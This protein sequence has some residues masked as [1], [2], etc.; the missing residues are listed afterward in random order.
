MMTVLSSAATSIKKIIASMTSPT[1]SIHLTF[2][3]HRDLVNARLCAGEDVVDVASPAEQ[4][5]NEL[6]PVILDQQ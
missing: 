5:K 3:M 4:T 6:I 2:I 1:V